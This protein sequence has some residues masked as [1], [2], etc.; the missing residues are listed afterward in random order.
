MIVKVQREL[1][2]GSVDRSVLIYNE[3][4]SI[5]LHAPMT[6]EIL[7]WFKKYQLKFYAEAELNGTIINLLNKVEEQDW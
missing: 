1:T 3:N 7:K 5:Y 6:P 2:T 4:M